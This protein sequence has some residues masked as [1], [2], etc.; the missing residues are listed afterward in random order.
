[1]ICMPNFKFLSLSPSFI[2][3][4]F[5]WPNL[6]AFDS[7]LVNASKRSAKIW[8]YES[9]GSVNTHNCSMKRGIKQK[10][11]I[12]FSYSKT[13]K[14]LHM[15]VASKQVFAKSWQLKMIRNFKRMTHTHHK[16]RH[17]KRLSMNTFCFVVC[18]N[19]FKKRI[20]V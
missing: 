2:V 20:Y 11:T 16:Q 1:M 5:Q 7:I 8:I 3:S 17:Y 14:Y 18:Q 6:C 10:K 15:F 9:F 12:P 19:V 4:K 13:N